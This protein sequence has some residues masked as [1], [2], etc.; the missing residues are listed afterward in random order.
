[1]VSAQLYFLRRR[2]PVHVQHD[3][4]AAQRCVALWLVAGECR[5]QPAR[6]VGSK[7]LFQI[8]E[9]KGQKKMRL[10][11]ETG[12]RKAEDIEVKCKGNHLKIRV[13]R[14]KKG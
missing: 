2:F 8:V 5:R 10:V 14:E 7:E 9:E 12:P 11:F 1:M 13:R 4:G 3:G 6:K